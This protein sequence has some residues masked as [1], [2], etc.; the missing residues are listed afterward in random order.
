MKKM[1][2]Q[3]ELT[4]K[5]KIKLRTKESAKKFKRELK[6]SINTAI[7]AAFSFL[8][9]LAWRD[10]IT[11]YVSKISELSPVKG[12]LISAI[13]I[14]IICVMGILIITKIFAKE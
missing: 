9:A 1:K 6:K 12:Q 8:I 10:V 11:G 5:D 2:K 14:T 4:K 7:V 3:R 13:I